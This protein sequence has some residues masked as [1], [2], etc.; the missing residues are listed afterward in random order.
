MESSIKRESAQGGFPFFF[1]ACRFNQIGSKL[2]RQPWGSA[3]IQSFY[4][5][6]AKAF[7][8]RKHL[9]TEHGS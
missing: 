8:I 5:L 7:T 2:I 9:T 1:S 6:W 4:Y 3:M